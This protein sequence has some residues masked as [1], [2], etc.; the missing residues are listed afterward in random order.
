MAQNQT[1]EA[2]MRDE[3]E[4]PPSGPIGLHRGQRSWLAR[5]LPYLITLIVAVALAVGTWLW[6]SGKGRELFSGTDSSSTSQTSTTTN[7]SKD[8]DADSS[9]SDTS[10]DTSSTSDSKASTSSKDSSTSGTKTDSSDSDSSDSKSSDSDSK[11]KDS[12]TATTS[13]ADT[14]KSVI[15]YNG[16]S[17]RTAGFAG[18]KASVLKSAGYTNVAAKNPSGSTNVTANVVWYK[19][20]ADEATAKDVASKLGISSVVQASAITAPVAVMYVTR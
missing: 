13:S 6:M 11:S 7:K 4:N 15:I 16:L 14:S 1:N 20:A 9:K 2:P 17:S 10:S 3:F 12:T 5:L 19:T 8:S 18:T